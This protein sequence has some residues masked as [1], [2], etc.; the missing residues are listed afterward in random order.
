[1]S[2]PVTPAQ[3]EAEMLGQG[4]YGGTLV[5][6][7]GSDGGGSGGGAGGGGS[8]STDGWAG[9]GTVRR[10]V[11]VVRGVVGVGDAVVAGTVAGTGVVVTTGA[12]LAVVA[13]VWSETVFRPGRV[14]S[15][16]PAIT[17]PAVAPMM[18]TR[19][20]NA[21]S[22]Q[23]RRGPRPGPVGSAASA[24]STTG[25][26]IGGAAGSV[27]AGA[28]GALVAAPPK[29]AVS[30]A[31]TSTA[32][33]GCVPDDDAGC[34]ATCSPTGATTAPRSSSPNRSAPTSSSRRPDP[35][36]GVGGRA[37]SRRSGDPSAL[38]VPNSAS[39]TSCCHLSGVG[40]EIGLSRTSWRE[41][42]ARLGGS[43]PSASAAG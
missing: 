4:R 7:G 24:L 30:T 1:M 33:G 11:A 15:D 31:S 19:A 32:R 34:H 27:A 16:R 26:S 9:G 37:V 41:P 39:S 6:G 13:V 8:D 23:T 29:R 21:A 40:N 3:A 5:D 2:P 28:E 12:V 18:T 25:S 35:A 43:R 17:A 14:V 36:S 20:V 22:T 10:V 42:R 38:W